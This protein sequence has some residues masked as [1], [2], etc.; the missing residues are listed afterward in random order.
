MKGDGQTFR[1]VGY[2]TVGSRKHRGPGAGFPN[3]QREGV[4]RGNPSLSRGQSAFVYQD[5][6]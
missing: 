5:E 4:E 1:G 3:S 2:S 6:F